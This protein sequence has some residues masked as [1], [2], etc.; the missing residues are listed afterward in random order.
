M[1]TERKPRLSAADLE[2]HRGDTEQVKEV[3]QDMSEACLKGT[4]TQLPRPRSRSIAAPHLYYPSMNIVHEGRL[5]SGVLCLFRAE[6]EAVGKVVRN[7]R[8]R[9]E[10]ILEASRV[11]LANNRR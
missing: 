9:S 5:R 4:L 7:A 10:R 1:A 3:C 11:G 2:T 8:I 6:R